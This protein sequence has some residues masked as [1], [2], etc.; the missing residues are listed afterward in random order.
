MTSIPGQRVTFSE[1]G[2][3]AGRVIGATGSA[4]GTLA[5]I[6]AYGSA[7]TRAIVA[8]IDQDGL[9]RK[10][11]VVGRY[12]APAPARLTRPRALRIA[13]SGSRA[14]VTWRKVPGASSY[15]V[16]VTYDAGYR[17]VRAVRGTR[18]VLDRV[19]GNRPVVVSVAAVDGQRH[20]GQAARARS[21]GH[22]PVVRTRPKKR[23]RPH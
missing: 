11:E 5:F 19:F 21:D 1:R 2:H 22:M 6:P 17:T 14:S 8:D 4:S 7:G 20:T 12:R 23:H 16:A 9:P 3:G 10:R 18:L 15:L 13:R